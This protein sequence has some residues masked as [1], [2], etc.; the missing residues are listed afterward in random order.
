MLSF[1]VTSLGGLV[2]EIIFGLFTALITR[3]TKEVRVIEP[4]CVIALAHLPYLVTETFHRSRMISM[5]G[6]G[7]L[8]SSYAINDKVLFIKFIT[9]YK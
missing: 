2:V 8:Q 6:C 5:T 4:L 3:F 7:I 1:F 9:K